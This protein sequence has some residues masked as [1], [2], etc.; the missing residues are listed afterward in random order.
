MMLNPG[1]RIARILLAAFLAVAA[2]GSLEVEAATAQLVSDAL[3]VPRGTSQLVN[4]P[5]AVE[6]VSIGDPDVADAVVVSPREILVNGRTLGTTTLIV[7]DVAGG[8]R[9]ISIEVTVDAPNLQRQLT[10]LYP[11]QNISVTASGNLVIVSGSVTDRA[12]A[13]R[14]IEIAAGTGATVVDNLQVPPPRQVLL[15][16]RFAEV[17]QRSLDRLGADFEVG[18]TSALLNPFVPEPGDGVIRTLSE[19]LVEL[20]LFQDDFQVSAVLEALSRDGTFRSLAE[21]NL[22][23]LEGREAAFLA[24]GEFPYPVPQETGGNGSTITIAFKEYGVRLRFLPTITAT[25]SIRLDVSPEVSSLDFASGVSFAGF[26]VPALLTRRAETS[27][28]LRDGQTFAIAGLLDNNAQETISRI[29]I[30]G[31]IP[32]LG[33]LFSRR[34]SSKNRTE[35]LVIVT[36]RIVEPSDVAPVLPVRDPLEWGLRPPNR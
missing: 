3:V 15:N 13:Q 6:R 12:I 14:A 4:L 26:N 21:P 2:A 10:T 11:G 16:V 28:E 8:M 1:R 5:S 32:V 27:I 31:H 35:L 34:E 7:W 24:G 25:G 29:P 30:L 33:L 9:T 36:P 20:F 22:L 17:S 23:A 19:G 18:R